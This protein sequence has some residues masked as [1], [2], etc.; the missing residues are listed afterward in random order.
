MPPMC[1]CIIRVCV[2]P[3][4]Y[5]ICYSSCLSHVQV[6]R[7][8]TE[9]PKPSE[10]PPDSALLSGESSG[11]VNAS[12]EGLYLELVD[13]T[14]MLPTASLAQQ[15]ALRSSQ[16]QPRPKHDQTK[17]P[18][19]I[20]AARQSAEDAP[21]PRTA[22]PPQ[23]VPPTATG[24]FRKRPSIPSFQFYAMIKSCS[25]EQCISGWIACR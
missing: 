4:P 13:S 23:P 24:A 6:K 20:T 22:L 10:A 3:C 15:A 25:G 12:L 14:D 18:E 1:T 9:M 5:H 19:I 8:L 2:Y 21:G 7:W 16:Q 11:Y 17:S